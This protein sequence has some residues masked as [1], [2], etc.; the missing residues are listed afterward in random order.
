MKIRKRIKTYYIIE[1]DKFERIILLKCGIQISRSFTGNALRISCSI[2]NSF[3]KSFYSIVKDFTW[4][5]IKLKNNFQ[6]I[7]T[8]MDVEIRKKH[9]LYIL[10]T[11]SKLR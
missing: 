4:A 5:S 8:M 9:G 2:K 6:C 11:N 1:K 10:T 7:Q 3:K